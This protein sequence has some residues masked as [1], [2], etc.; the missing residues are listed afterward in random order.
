[1]R[2]EVSPFLE[3]IHAERAED[4]DVA[5]ASELIEQVLKTHTGD[6]PPAHLLI[7]RACLPDGGASKGSS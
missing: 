1:M 2:I 5:L 4:R 6:T 3:V 7:A